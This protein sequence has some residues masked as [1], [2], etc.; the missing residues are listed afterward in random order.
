MEPDTETMGMRIRVTRM[1]R[2]IKQIDLAR[3]VGI[4]KNA[5]F[6]IEND[7]TDPRASRI[8]AIADVLGVT[9]DYLLA[10]TEPAHV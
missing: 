7:A 5:M 1:R 10:G 6:Q 3:R 9:T 4:S 8:K 2:R